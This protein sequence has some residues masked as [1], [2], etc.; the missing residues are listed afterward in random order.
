MTWSA[1][2]AAQSLLGG[3]KLEPRPARVSLIGHCF[4][5]LTVIVTVAPLASLIASPPGILGGEKSR[6]ISC[7]F[8]PRV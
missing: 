4:L 5:W 8:I 3:S 6:A 7:N 1:S 2:A